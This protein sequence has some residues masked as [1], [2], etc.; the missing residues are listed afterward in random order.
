MSRKY[1]VFVR[2]AKAK[3]SITCTNTRDEDLD[4]LYAVIKH[5]EDDAD[6]VQANDKLSVV[7]GEDKVDASNEEYDPKQSGGED[8]EAKED[9]DRNDKDDDGDAAPET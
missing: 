9:D 6:F 8:S 3:K 2:Q 1:I 7:D 4:I 5:N